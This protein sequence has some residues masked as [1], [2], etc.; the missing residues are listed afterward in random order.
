MTFQ[1][2]AQLGPFGESFNFNGWVNEANL[3]PWLGGT[4]VEGTLSETY[5]YWGH[6]PGPQA[7]DVS[8]YAQFIPT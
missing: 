3:K 2:S 7:T 4:W 8:G 5:T 1:G 6:T